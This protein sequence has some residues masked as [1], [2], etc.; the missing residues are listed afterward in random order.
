MKKIAILI[1]MLA[2]TIS[3][4]K[5]DDIER[6]EEPEQFS[7][8]AVIDNSTTKTQLTGDGSDFSLEWSVF[9][10]FSLFDG[11]NSFVLDRKGET[12]IFTLK[13]GTPSGSSFHAYYPSSGCNS[14]SGEGFIIDLPKVQE[15][16]LG[17]IA[18]GVAPMMGVKEGNTMKFQK[19]G[20]LLAF[21][22]TPQA[23]DDG[24]ELKSVTLTAEQALSGTWSV[25]FGSQAM[26]LVNGK[27]SL[28]LDC[29]GVPLTAGQE[30]KF[31]F[32]IPCGTYSG[33]KLSLE[34]A[35][36][37]FVVEYDIEGEHT[38]ARANQYPME[39]E[40]KEFSNEEYLTKIVEKQIADGCSP[41]VY[42][43]VDVDYAPGQFTNTLP[44]GIET[45]A[46]AIE[47]TAA[48]MVGSTRNY[49]HLGGWG[50]SVTV[51][52]DHPVINLKGADFR[53]YGNAFE[54][55]SEPGV[56]YVA[57]KDDE[58]KPEKWYLI[59][60]SMY[61]YSIHDYRITY[62]KPVSEVLTQYKFFVWKG[63]YAS[64]TSA[65][66]VTAFKK[67]GQEIPSK[68][69]NVD[70]WYLYNDNIY[71]EGSGSTKTIMK[72]I[73]ANTLVGTAA[74][75][76]AIPQTYETYPVVFSYAKTLEAF[77]EYIYWEDNKGHN[78]YECKNS[79]HKQSYWPEYAGETIVITGEYLP[80]NSFDTSGGG[81]NYV[82]DA[83]WW[84]FPV[85]AELQ[86]EDLNHLDELK[87]SKTTFGLGAW[88][89]CDNYPNAHPLSTIDIDWAVDENGNHVYLD[90]IDFIKVQS[91]THRQAGWLGE[92]ST[93]FCGVEDLHLL[94][95]KITPYTGVT[96]AIDKIPQSGDPLQPA[97]GLLYWSYTPVERP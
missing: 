96:P 62:Y 91:A 10:S 14:V 11:T 9:D 81:S 22:F 42:S 46:S 15:F 51:G 16:T 67:N 45:K 95:E 41:Y 54:G 94:G 87:V 79:Y 70:K 21:G 55:S 86:G 23:A 77:D 61:D 17:N 68:D 66:T 47:A 76:D 88:G 24:R 2:F 90:H 35:D 73:Q 93:E 32:A 20:A 27:D 71:K 69:P 53:G 28:I 72:L 78:G 65:V 64:K 30:I 18:S 80:V 43:V 50:G 7:I 34:G 19:L 58:G 97:S 59:K 1:S 82:Q 89:Y 84:G 36:E 4:Q 26:E 92:I 39:L 83:K 38:F 40:A 37:G 57:Q 56:Y 12:N 33:M 3:C 52:F 85:E 8:E 6:P 25:A 49:V 74:S 5:S 60:H 29:A 31:F 13:E 44:E 75:E 63:D 48:V